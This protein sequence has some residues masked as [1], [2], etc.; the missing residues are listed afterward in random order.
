MRRVEV[1]ASKSPSVSILSSQ[2]ASELKLDAGSD[3]AGKT[4]RTKTDRSGVTRALKDEEV[5]DV[6]SRVDC[7]A[8]VRH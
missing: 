4:F 2:L 1:R 6:R 3:A 5:R 7:V 8:V